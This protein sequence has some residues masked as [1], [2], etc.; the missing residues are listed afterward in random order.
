ME[1]ISEILNFLVGA[2][3]ALALGWLGFQEWRKASKEQ[4]IAMVE[5]VV[6]AVEQMYPHNLGSDKLT[7]AIE[8]LQALT[9]WDDIQELRELI[10]ATV[11]K[12]N[13]AKRGGVSRSAWYE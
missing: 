6:L 5:R 12:L 11:A 4:K 3:V 7:L 1:N 9:R 10:E 13:A 8:R 2:I